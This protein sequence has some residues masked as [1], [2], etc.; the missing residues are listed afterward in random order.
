[1]SFYVSIFL[2]F[3]G[4]TF[5]P[6]VYSLAFSF[7]PDSASG[8]F[9]YVYRQQQEMKNPLFHLVW[10]CA[11]S[12]TRNE[13]LTYQ[14]NGYSLTLFNFICFDHIIIMQ[15]FSFHST[16]YTTQVLAFNKLDLAQ[17]MKNNDKKENLKHFFR[18][19]KFLYY[20]GGWIFVVLNLNS[21]GYS[22]LKCLF[23][24]V[25][26]F[27]SRMFSM[28]QPLQQTALQ[29]LKLNFSKYLWILLSFIKL[30][31][32][33]EVVRLRFLRLLNTK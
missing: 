16:K 4:V 3:H 9:V 6:L 14:S 27:I 8:G 13:P 7:Q 2:F 28:S 20:F 24:Y 11:N 10:A 26:S 25:Y 29:E 23:F 21:T 30:L 19:T 15:I 32:M 5:F 1:M 31:F 22:N 17:W 18:I 33:N 12:R